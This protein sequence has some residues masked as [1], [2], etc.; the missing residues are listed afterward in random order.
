MDQVVDAL[1]LGQPPDEAERDR[2][3]GA[4][5]RRVDRCDQ[6][7]VADHGANRRIEKQSEVAVNVE[8]SLTDADDAVDMAGGAAAVHRQDLAAQ[9][10]VRAGVAVRE[11][12]TSRAAEIVV[13]QGMYDRNPRFRGHLPDRCRETGQIVGVHDV[14]SEGPYPL[15]NQRRG[16]L[17]VLDRMPDSAQWRAMLLREWQIDI[18]HRCRVNRDAVGNFH[19]LVCRRSRADYLDAVARCCKRLGELPGKYLG[20]PDNPGGLR[21]RIH[22]TDNQYSHRHNRSGP[23]NPP[24]GKFAKSP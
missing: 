7:G 2:W 22:R 1:L 11:T 18:A 4:S 10:S 9:A 5:V 19:L 24:S 14:G 17:P 8:D 20:A 6:G 13:V 23:K 12:R 16:L 21:G 15:R 3:I